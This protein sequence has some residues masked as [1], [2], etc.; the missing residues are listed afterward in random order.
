VEGKVKVSALEVDE[1]GPWAEEEM[2]AAVRAAAERVGKMGGSNATPDV[3]ENLMVKAYG[4]TMPMKGMAQVTADKEGLKL[5]VQCFDPSTAGAVQQAIDGANMGLFATADPQSPGALV[6]PIP[7]LDAV[8][9][10]A[11]AKSAKEAAEAGKAHVRHIRQ[12]AIAHIKQVEKEKRASK[13]EAFAASQKIEAL[14]AKHV[15]G[16]GADADKVIAKVLGR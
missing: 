10:Q 13:D 3:L 7:Q 15:A 12:Q 5:T 8:R 11:A 14:T 2:A 4:G 1:V 6:V 16:I 9:R